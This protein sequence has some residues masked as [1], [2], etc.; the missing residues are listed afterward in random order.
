MRGRLILLA[1]LAVATTSCGITPRPAPTPAAPSPPEIVTID[2][3]IHHLSAVPA[4]NDQLAE[5]AVREKVPATIVNS[6]SGR[7]PDG[8]VVLF[9]HGG[10]SPSEVAFDL[11]YRDYSW[12]TFLARAGFDVFA[13]D[14]TGYGGS[15][16]PNMDDPCNVDPRHQKALIPKTLKAACKASYPHQLVTSDS[17]A[18]DIDAVVEFIRKLRGVGRVS[19]VGWSGGGIRVG[20]YAVRHPYKIDKLVILAS[21]NYSRT[22]P[23]APPGALPA[24]GFPIVF[25]PRAV[26]EDERW[27]PNVKCPDQ[28]DPAIRDVVWK[29][30]MASDPV[31]AGWG[32]GGLRAPTRTYWGWNADN[33]TKIRLPT[34]IMVGEDDRLMTSN[35]EL[36]DDLGTTGKV[37]LTMQCASHFSV[38]EMQHRILQK[39]SLEWLRSGTVNGVRIGRL[40]ADARGAI[41]AAPAKPKPGAEAK[42]EPAPKPAPEAKPEAEPEPKPEPKPEPTP[43]SE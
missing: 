2:R 17:E 35:G 37:L 43:K 18:A 34:L 42:P 40:R 28:V 3:V 39:A 41:A 29:E 13:M 15:T 32:P 14:M 38:W 22:G 36:Y 31:G 26:A 6:A 10:F 30:A 9:V 23:S 16:R 12:M 33:A 4:I 25:Q 27:T 11:P 21:S 19:L 7:A 20:T 8:R 24:P 1:A 5:L